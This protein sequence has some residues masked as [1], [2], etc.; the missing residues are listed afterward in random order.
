MEPVT[1]VLTGA[2][3]AR[4]GLNRRAA[5][6][7][8]A[9][10][11]A[12]EFPDI[13]TLWSLRGPV[14]GFQHHRGI[15]HTFLGIPFEA[16]LLLLGFVLYH[17]M[18]HR[19]ERSDGT[20]DS[21]SIA[22]RQNRRGLPVAAVRWGALYGL[23][24]LALMSHILLDFTN[25]YGVRPFF[26]FQ[27]SW[28]A[29]S[30]VFIFDPL[31]FVFLLAGLLLPSIFGLVS[32][33]VGV[34]RDGFAGRGWARAALLCI[35]L[36]WSVRWY[37]HGRA[38]TAAQTQTLRAPSSDPATASG[39]APGP[40]TG[41]AGQPADVPADARPLLL[42]A[43]S[44]A[45]PDPLSVFRW[46]TATDFGPAYRTAVVDSRLETVDAQSVLV[47]LPA[48]PALV[49]AETSTLGRVYLDWSPMPLLRVQQGVPEGAQEEW[50]ST[51]RTQTV[52]FTDLRF[53][54]DMPI[55]QRSGRTPL[56]GQV[57][58]SPDK[59]AV[60][61]AMDGRWETR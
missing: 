54:G 39:L 32:R 58:V 22:P 3:L 57:V 42:P 35:V 60:A 40:T 4:S 9:M 45:S 29:G 7:T 55:V 21:K 47:K 30:F 33:E 56:T 52:T 17:R 27:R 38:V 16:A 1:H 41:L 18:R 28:Y 25:N 8:A 37:E 12:A 43:R 61:Q 53:V 6:A 36:L 20:A 2:C 24:V 34:R 50:H 59:G 51:A 14:E 19:S 23:I 26:P 10:A 31:I 11:I 5:Y 13:D 44:L 48:S 46:Y 15:T 49:A